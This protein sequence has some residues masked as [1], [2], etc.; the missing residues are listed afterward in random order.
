[1]VPWILYWTRC[2][3]SSASLL[4]VWIWELGE[5]IKHSFEYLFANPS[6]PSSL[7]VTVAPLPPL[8]VTL[9]QL[10]QMKWPLN[11]EMSNNVLAELWTGAFP[12]LYGECGRPKSICHSNVAAQILLFC[13]YC[14]LTEKE[15]WRKP[16]EF[17]WL[18]GDAFFCRPSTEIK[19]REISRA[20][21]PRLALLILGRKMIQTMNHGH[22]TA[23]APLCNFSFHFS[24]SPKLSVHRLRA[25]V[26]PHHR[27]NEEEKKK[28][29][30][31]QQSHKI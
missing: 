8:G 6:K 4:A 10:H 16:K 31:R 15:K 23:Y 19:C 2:V 12:P 25:S 18:T 29:T 21:F 13:F 30:F 22:A 24:H 11:A 26:S 28:K 17:E 9:A 20:P 3:T 7:R 27:R 5:W 14:R 1:M